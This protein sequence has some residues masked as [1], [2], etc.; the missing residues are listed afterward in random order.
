M[1]MSAAVTDAVATPHPAQHL[2]RS[3]PAQHLALRTLRLLLNHSRIVGPQPSG[4]RSWCRS[5]R[6]RVAALSSMHHPNGNAPPDDAAK[7]AP[8][9][10]EQVRRRLPIQSLIACVRA[11]VRLSATPPEPSSPRRRPSSLAPPPGDR[12]RQGWLVH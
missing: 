8:G 4:V 7:P 9:T 2:S 10:A 12:C 5:P 3:P 11:I 1:R 6:R